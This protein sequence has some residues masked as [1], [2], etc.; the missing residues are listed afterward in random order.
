MRKLQPGETLD[1]F[2]IERELHISA[3]ASLYKVKDII[4]GNP[5]VIKV[6]LDD[7]INNPTI[8]YHHQN[9]DR[10]GRMLKSPYVV[11]YFDRFKSH[12]YSVMEYIEGEDLRHA[13]SKDAPLDLEI[14]LDIFCQ[15]A[16]GGAYLH[17]K[18][19]LHLDLKPENIMLTAQGKVKL[20]DFGL[21]HHLDFGDYLNVDFGDPKGTPYYISPEQLC[22]L[23]YLKQSDIYCLAMVLYEM[24]TGKVPF[25]KT[26][27]LAKTDKRRK[28]DPVPPRY[29]NPKLPAGVQNFILSCLQ[30]DPVNRL[31]SFQECIESVSNYKK[32]PKGQYGEITSKPLPL[33]TKYNTLEC[34]LLHER[35]EL[36]CGLKTPVNQAKQILVC[37][38]DNSSSDA[39]IDWLHR[40]AVGSTAKITL[41]HI[42]E[43]NSDSEFEKYADEVHGSSLFRR[44]DGYLTYLN[45]YEIY[46]LLR[47]K[48]G[49]AAEV[50][51]QIAKDT[52]ADLIVIGRPKRRSRIS[53][54]FTGSVMEKI[55][56]EGFSNVIVAQSPVTIEP[57]PHVDLS[58]FTH[59]EVQRLELFLLDCWVAHTDLLRDISLLPD[60]RKET[61]LC[62]LAKWMLQLL[63]SPKKIDGIEHLFDLDSKFHS[64]LKELHQPILLEEHHKAADIYNQHLYPLL[65]EI[66]SH[67][68]SLM[69]K[70]KSEIALD[71]GKQQ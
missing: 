41:L 42:I 7:L 69:H 66:K 35:A 52:Q 57:P 49:D 28:I 9:E 51:T 38:A 65:T 43:E 29:Y 6:P 37:I 13:I 67:I 46:P 4:S 24:V 45:K 34:S 39:V 25:E 53:K 50:I 10:I 5:F 59:K 14:A 8:L 17:S 30:K 32:L 2:K 33:F 71:R 15:A 19:I 36:T 56:D 63:N 48:N 21:A 20:I 60:D 22:G 1:T 18:N 47:I 70:I 16:E 26:T 62:D 64:Y 58:S 61:E 3:V 40:E 11:R 23:R 44:L 27:S 68:H 54:I 55:V 12:Q 31:Q